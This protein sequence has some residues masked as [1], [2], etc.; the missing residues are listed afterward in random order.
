MLTQI[1]RDLN[2]YFETEIYTGKFV[3]ENGE[4][5]LSEIVNEGDLRTGQ[6]FRIAGSVFNDGIYQYPATELQDEEFNGA[7]WCMAIPK[8]FLDLVA[9]I[10][11]WSNKYEDMVASPYQSESFGGYSYSKASGT[12][13]ENVSYKTQFKSELN[14]WRKIR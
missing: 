3:I 13:G 6:Y 4:I 5:D 14:H 2:N 7:V 10:T 12:S 8:D 11:S 1:C 9:K